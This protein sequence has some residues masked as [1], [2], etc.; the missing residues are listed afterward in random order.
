MAVPDTRN[1]LQTV[2]ISPRVAGTFRPDTSQVS[3]S[4]SYYTDNQKGSETILID[5]SEYNK[6]GQNGRI[7]ALGTERSGSMRT[8]PRC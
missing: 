8:I 3:K 1:N 6:Y 5:I 4:L 7:R 2:M